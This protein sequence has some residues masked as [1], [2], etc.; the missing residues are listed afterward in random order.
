[1]RNFPKAIHDYFEIFPA[2]KHPQGYT[3]LLQDFSNLYS[4]KDNLLFSTWPV[5]FP[6]IFKIAES[7]KDSYL[8]K[9][10]HDYKAQKQ[11]D[12]TGNI[13]NIFIR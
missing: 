13:I 7:K 9:I 4:E 1:M 2:L 8:Q 3:L 5:I 6:K 12:I 11:N 10:I